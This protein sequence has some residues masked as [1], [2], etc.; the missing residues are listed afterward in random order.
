MSGGEYIGYS[1]PNAKQS[2]AT[3]IK[4]V[5]RVPPPLWR[6]FCIPYPGFSITT[7]LYSHKA[8]ILATSCFYFV[9]NVQL[10]G[11]F[12]TELKDIYCIDD[13]HKAEISIVG[14]G[15]SNTVSKF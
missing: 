12:M 10:N 6:H 15:A 8:R 2:Q 7:C 1:L 9:Y 3:I 4:Q 5:T 14:S 11:E 13:S